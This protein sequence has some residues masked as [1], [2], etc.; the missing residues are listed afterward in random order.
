M[1]GPGENTTDPYHRSPNRRIGHLWGYPAIVSEN[2]VEVYQFEQSISYRLGGC[3]WE[4]ELM[5][6]M[7]SLIDR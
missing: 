1:H 3:Y 2:N 4:D 6:V 7:E 5:A